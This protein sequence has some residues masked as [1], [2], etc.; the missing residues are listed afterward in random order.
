V[1]AGEGGDDAALV[2]AL[3]DV[4]A[5]TGGRV[6]LYVMTHEH[7][8]HVQGLRYAAERGYE[9]AI[10]T[11]WMTASSAPDYYQTHPQAREKKLA[12][13]ADAWAFTRAL[14]S[15]E[16]APTLRLMLDLNL[17]RSTKD[18]VDYIRA[19]S[20]KVYHLHRGRRLA[21]KHPFTETRFRILAPEE[22][23]SVNYRPRRA[24]L[25][26][27]ASGAAAAGGAEADAARP[28]PLPGIDA[29]AC[30]QLIDC[31]NAGVADGVRSID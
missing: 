24:R 9:L 5:R 14:G 10:D 23:T 30:Y 18:Y 31:P 17:P 15:T 8:D 4:I 1:L 11:V 21:G 25:A 16:L 7:L 3:Q 13:E 29:G 27:D 28:V 19:R 22:D 20:A 2:A 6:D 12:L 26:G